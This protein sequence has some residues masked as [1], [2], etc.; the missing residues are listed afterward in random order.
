M[1]LHP[2]NQMQTHPFY[3][4]RY[5][6]VEVEQEGLRAVLR[7]RLFTSSV[8][9][10]SNFPPPLQPRVISRHSWGSLQDWEDSLTPL[11]DT[12][13]GATVG[14]AVEPEAPGL[15]VRARHLHVHSRHPALSV[16]VTQIPTFREMFTFYNE[17]SLDIDLNLLFYS[18]WLSPSK[19]LFVKY[20]N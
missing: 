10:I 16:S 14:P 5:R 6:H 8:L 11:L 9:Y 4:T 19:M 1:E 3:L 2:I 20:S 12:E 7:P 13:R 18:L 17:D 15:P